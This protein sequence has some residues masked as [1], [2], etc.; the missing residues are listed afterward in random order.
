[1]LIAIVHPH[2]LE[3]IKKNTKLKETLAEINRIDMAAVNAALRPQVNGLAH[4]NKLTNYVNLTA[5][6]KAYGYEKD[7]EVLEVIS[8]D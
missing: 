7:D 4:S 6:K 8:V 3:D 5:I 1:M 2:V